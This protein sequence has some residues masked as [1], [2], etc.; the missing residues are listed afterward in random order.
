MEL[1]TVVKKIQGYLVD[2]PLTI[3]G[4][5]AS[6]PYG[7][8]TM[9]ELGKEIKKSKIIISDPVAKLFF[10]SIDEVGLE[11]AI[12]RHD[13]SSPIK[14]EIR[15]ITWGYI[16]AS[17]MECFQRI[18]EGERLDPLVKLIKKVISPSPNQTSIV[19]TNY[20]RLIEYAID[21]YGASIVTGFEGNLIKKFDGFSTDINNKR[22]RARERVVK[23]LKVHGSLDWFEN[24]DEMIS[25]PLTMGSPEDYTPLI[26]P[27]GKDKYSNTHSEPYR[28][29]ISEADKEF[30]LAKSFLSVGYGFNDLHIQPI[31]LEQVRE[32]KPIVVIT[33]AATDSCHKLIIDADLPRYVVLEAD[34]KTEN[35][36]KVYSDEGSCLIDR[37]IWS[38]DEFMEVW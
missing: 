13:I 37:N 11:A 28:T 34:D 1:E 31:L 38:L 20:D 21:L 32:G 16:N 18:I 36:T 9:N 26:V 6:V 24:A 12:D 7:F 29:I 14:E 25:T 35:N 4:S 3:L 27:P 23:I 5:G 8:P 19:T 22:V 15:R 10:E 2:S 17:D 33:K 30:K